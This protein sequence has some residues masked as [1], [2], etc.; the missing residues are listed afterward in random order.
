MKDDINPELDE[1]QREA[2]R[3]FHAELDLVPIVAKSVARLIGTCVELDELLA[4][5]R[6]GLFDAAHRY[7]STRG[8]PFRSYANI[9]VQGAVIDAIRQAGPLPRRVYKRLRALEAET[10]TASSSSWTA[11]TQELEPSAVEDRLVGCAMAMATSGA[12]SM[13]AGHIGSII[14]ESHGQ[15]PGSPEDAAAYSELRARLSEVL[16]NLN[17][18]EATIIRHLYFDDLSFRQVAEALEVSRSWVVR[19]HAR[20][21]VRMTKLMQSRI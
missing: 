15:A 12:A 2:E 17:S 14:G 7:D 3:L 6:A 9:R 20:A 19:L 10:L 8:V 13:A 11:S 5:G 4:A 18:D 1:R 21:M 16:T